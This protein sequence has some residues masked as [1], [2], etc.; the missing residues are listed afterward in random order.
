M[1][2]LANIIIF[3]DFENPY[4]VFENPIAEEK[5]DEIITNTQRKVLQHILGYPLFDELQNDN[6]GDL[7]ITGKWKDF[8]DGVTYLK[9]GVN[10]YYKGIKDVLTRM[11][12]RD[13]NI[14][15]Y[16]SLQENS[17]V[18]IK[19]KTSKQKTDKEL[20][21]SAYSEASEM[22]GNILDNEYK[23]SVYNYLNDTAGFDDLDFNG[24]GHINSLGI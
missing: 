4:M 1:S 3:E 6:G 18:Q 5:L 19:Q 16:T 20:N 23:P 22:V 24:Y 14:S 2:I 15:N 13:W 21:V 12:F 8:I 10:I 11:T 17:R 9:N 7:P